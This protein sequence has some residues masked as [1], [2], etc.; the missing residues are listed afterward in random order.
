[1]NKTIPIYTTQN[2]D[3][4]VRRKDY[5]HLGADKLLVTWF[6]RTIQGEGPF[7]G[8][9]AVFL[10]LAG[11]NFGDKQDHC[12]WCDTS[13][14]FDKGTAYDFND[15]SYELTQ[16]PG[17]SATDILV[18]TGGEPTLQQNL[19]DYVLIVQESKMF[20]AVQVETNG[21]QA[22]FFQGIDSIEGSFEVEADEWNSGYVRP[23][24]VVSPK[25]STK[26]GRIPEPAEVV[27]RYANSFKFVL[28]ADPN[29]AQHTIPEWAHRLTCPVYV[30]P[31]AVYAK[32][33]EGEVSSI[34]TPGLI[35]FERTSRN[36]A[37]TAE[38][39]LK[40]NLRVSI[41]QHLF[42]GVA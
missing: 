28:S 13:F 32:P 34:W 31:M 24:I 26:A 29:D 35:D 14:Q 2:I 1:M 40:H 7:A 36:Y 17:Y 38:Y 20:A 12:A 16:L 33:Y 30:S 39:A 18:V 5:D 22:A 27:R 21:T 11:C 41:Q 9:T 25:A 19:L 6:G 15:L 42:L 37:Y 23:S 3:R 10:R 4:I 8:R